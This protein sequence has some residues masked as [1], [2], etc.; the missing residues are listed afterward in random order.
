MDS[1]LSTVDDTRTNVDRPIFGWYHCW[2][3]DSVHVL[4]II[5]YQNNKNLEHFITNLKSSS[6]LL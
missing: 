5:L 1:T 6:F 2:A 3:V 4:H